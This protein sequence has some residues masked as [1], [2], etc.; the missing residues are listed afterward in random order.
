MSLV[1]GAIQVPKCGDQVIVLTAASGR[2]GSGESRIGR[3]CM[4]AI[5]VSERADVGAKMGG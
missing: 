5:A 4:Q 3:C 1:L 2:D